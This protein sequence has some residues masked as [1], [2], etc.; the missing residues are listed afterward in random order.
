MKGK[1]IVID[2][3]DGS[4]KTTQIDLL[5]QYLKQKNIP[6]EIISFPQY[7]KNKYTVQIKRYLEGKMGLTEDLDPYSIAKLYANDRLT[8]RDLI[9]GWL[10]QGKLVI[11]NRYISSNK[12]HQG[13]NL[14]DKERENFL[15]WLEELEYQTNGMPKPNLTILLK[16]DAKVGQQNAIKDHLKDI[17]EENLVHEGKAAKIYLKLSQDEKNW[18]VINC[19]RDGNLRNKND[20][21]RELIKVISKK[22]PS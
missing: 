19:M 20:I 16:L 7:G 22:L 6:F 14:V 1:L 17:H 5:S 4:G 21:F 2:G 11:A 8:A 15:K 10:D 13:A 9:R 18:E 3:I 12:A